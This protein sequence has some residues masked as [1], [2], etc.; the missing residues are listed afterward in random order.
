MTDETR[1]AEIRQR[2]EAEAGETPYDLNQQLAALTTAVQTVQAVIYD[3][4][5]GHDIQWVQGNIRHAIRGV[6]PPV[7]IAALSKAVGLSV[8]ELHALDPMNRLAAAEAEVERMRARA[9]NAEAGEAELG[10]VIDAI[11]SWLNGE[12]FE[13]SAARVPEP[14]EAVSTEDAQ[15]FLQGHAAAVRHVKAILG[16]DS[17]AVLARVKAEAVASVVTDQARKHWEW[18]EARRQR[19][20]DAG[21]TCDLCGVMA[22]IA[23]AGEDQ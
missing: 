10:A 22:N 17:S 21:C 11:W 3:T 2:A 13:V 5:Y 15:G 9:W 20:N 12:P 4:K 23:Q 7:D 6:T 14:V 8:E 16:E 19:F 1:V 18:A